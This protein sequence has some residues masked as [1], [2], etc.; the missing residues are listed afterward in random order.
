MLYLGP[1]YLYTRP[2]DLG[3]IYLYTRPFNASNQNSTTWGPLL[4][5]G[6]IYLYTRPFD[7]GPIYLYTRPFD[8]SNQNST[9]WGPLLYLG[10]IY[11]YARPIGIEISLYSLSAYCFNQKIDFISFHTLQTACLDVSYEQS[12]SQNRLNQSKSSIL[13]IAVSIFIEA[14]IVINPHTRLY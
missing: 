6:P 13:F 5:L 3:P 4:Y 11:L 14:L 2:F 1:I 10:P 8:A 12:Y 7:L 9:T